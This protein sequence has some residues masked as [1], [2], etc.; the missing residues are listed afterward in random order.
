MKNLLYFVALLFSTMIFAQDSVTKDYFPTDNITIA[1]DHQKQYGKLIPA[2]YAINNTKV[3]TVDNFDVEY[4]EKLAEGYIAILVNYDFR[5]KDFTISLKS[6][7][8]FN[9]KTK[10]TFLLTSDSEKE[11]VRDYC[12]LIQ[13]MFVTF[14]AEYISTISK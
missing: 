13:M 2:K 5:K 6:I 11:E 1:K 4:R 12:S 9:D 3:H 14:Q 8:Y 7:T 10:R